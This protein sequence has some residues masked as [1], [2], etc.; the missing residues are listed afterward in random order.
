MIQAAIDPW[1]CRENSDGVEKAGGDES[2]D[3][4]ALD[5]SPRCH[6]ENE[7]QDEPHAAGEIE[8]VLKTGGGG[9]DFVAALVCGRGGEEIA[10]PRGKRLQGHGH[11]VV[12]NMGV[13]S[14][15]PA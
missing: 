10:H 12:G 8:A 6:V 7:D 15:A 11:T 14:E 1:A 9:R 2:E 4:G 3:H 13:R 5:C